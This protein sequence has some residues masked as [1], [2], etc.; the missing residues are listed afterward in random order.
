MIVTL[1][2]YLFKLILTFP[3][4]WIQKQI[5]FNCVIKSQIRADLKF[6]LPFNSLLINTNSHRHVDYLIKKIYTIYI[7]TVRYPLYTSSLYHNSSFIIL[8]DVFRLLSCIHM[9]CE[10]IY[11]NWKLISISYEWNYISRKIF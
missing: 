5:K 11:S 6:I 2:T 10:F 3:S 9:S 4:I 7:C 8:H 1:P